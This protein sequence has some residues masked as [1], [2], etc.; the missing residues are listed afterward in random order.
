MLLVFVVLQILEFTIGLMEKLL[1][2]N[3]SHRISELLDQLISLFDNANGVLLGPSISDWISSQGG[4]VRISKIKFF[5][6]AAH[7]V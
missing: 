3:C 4:W 6:V 2:N 7:W 5:C 1:K